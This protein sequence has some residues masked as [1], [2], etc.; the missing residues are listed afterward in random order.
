MYFKISRC[1]PF[2]TP[3][4]AFVCAIMLVLASGST[5]AAGQQFTTNSYTLANGMRIVVAEDHH[6][7]RVALHFFYKIGSRNE[8]QGMTGISHFLEHMMFNGALKYGPG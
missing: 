8:R 4:G 5:P 7:P 3:C 6:I 1:S 2:F